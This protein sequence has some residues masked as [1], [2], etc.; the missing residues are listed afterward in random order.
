[1]T[2]TVPHQFS[3]RK[4]TGLKMFARLVMA[5]LEVWYS[6]SFTDAATGLPNRQKLIRRLDTLRQ[7]THR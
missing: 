5:F 4:I 2:D 7:D 6:A 3:R 1:V